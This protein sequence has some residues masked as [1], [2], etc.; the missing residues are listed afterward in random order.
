MNRSGRP[1]ALQHRA[2]ALPLRC[3][4][5]VAISLGFLSVTAMTSKAAM[6]VQK[7][8]SPGGIEAWLVESRQVP[9]VT[10]R[11]AFSGGAAQDPEGKEGLAHFVSGMLDEG[12]GDLDSTA[13]QELQ[14]ELAVRMEF[15][16]G[17]DVFTGAF[18][19]LTRNRDKAFELLRL[20]LTEPRF[21]QDALERIKGQI[22]TGL[23]FD[24]NDPRKVASREWFSLAFAGHPY[25]R[26]T[27]GVASTVAG[28]TAEDLREYVRRVF[29][30]DTLKVA[31]VGDIDAETLGQVLDKVFGDLGEKSDLAPVPE[32]KPAKG[33]LRKVVEMN[34]PQSVVQFGH[35]GIKRK[36][37]DFV[38]SYVLNYILGGGGFNSRLMEEVREK[39]GLA[40]SVYSYLSPYRYAAV[41]VGSVATENKSVGRSIEVI[42]AELKRMA[43]KGPTEEELKNAKQYLTGSYALRFDTSSKIANQLLWVQIEDLGIDYTDK[44][45]SLIEAVTL[46]DVRRVAQRLLQ[47]DALIVTIVGKPQKS[48]TKPAKG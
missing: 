37:E 46:E 36:D 34:V 32:V 7:V 17:R 30:R 3:V 9:L 28:I 11:F 6:N 33:P 31:V 8:V 27:K 19:T 26:P 35:Q 1:F 13:F 14:E 40:Y 45:N 44:R 15:D 22:L 29:A 25:A 12:A 42:Q 24:D 23:K 41:Y 38:A 16:A 4:L 10:M 39:R 5:L 43:E 20:A 18:Q 47:A 48:G 21:D 2:F